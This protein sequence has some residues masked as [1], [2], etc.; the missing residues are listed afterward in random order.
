[1]VIPDYTP[2]VPVLFRHAKYIIHISQ[3]TLKNIKRTDMVLRKTGGLD[4]ST[5]K[6]T[7]T[8]GPNPTV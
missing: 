8:V 6:I 5:N 3:Y 7:K 4:R 1:M 2:Y